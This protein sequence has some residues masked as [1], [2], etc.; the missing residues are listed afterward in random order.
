MCVVKVVGLNREETRGER[1]RGTKYPVS[2]QITD[3]AVMAGL[4]AALA[5]LEVVLGFWRA[6]RGV[7]T[8]ESV[9]SGSDLGGEMEVWTSK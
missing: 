4:Y 5:V 2:D 6:A 3:V 9:A 8:R 7:R 1:R